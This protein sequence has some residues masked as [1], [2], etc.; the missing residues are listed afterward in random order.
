MPPVG[1]GNIIWDSS[2]T[3]LALN[4]NRFDRSNEGLLKLYLSD[5]FKETMD[6][7]AAGDQ[8]GRLHQARNA[9]ERIEVTIYNDFELF[10]KG[11]VRIYLGLNGAESIIV[12]YRWEDYSFD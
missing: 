9:L 5:E 10:K 6:P 11:R 8:N 2:P 7:T 1:V 4:S 12:Y 3:I